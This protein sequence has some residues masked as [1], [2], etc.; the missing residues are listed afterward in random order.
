M[1]RSRLLLPVVALMAPC[2]SGCQSLALDLTKAVPDG[3]LSKDAHAPMDG[4]GG[5]DAG[6]DASTHDAHDAHDG[7]TEDAVATCALGDAACVDATVPFFCSPNASQASFPLQVTG[8]SNPRFTSGVA[9]RNADRAFVFSG[10]AATDAGSPCAIYAQAFDLTADGGALGDAAPIYAPSPPNGEGLYIHDVATA[11]SGVML[12][13]YGFGG[14][15]FKSADLTY[16]GPLYALFLRSGHLGGGAVPGLAVVA[17]VTL[18]SATNLYGQAHVMW[19]DGAGLFHVSWEHPTESYDDASDYSVRVQTLAPDGGVVPGESYAQIPVPSDGAHVSRSAYQGGV[20]VKGGVLGVAYIDLERSA[21]RVALVSGSGLNDTVVGFGDAGTSFVVVAGTPAGF[22]YV[23]YGYDGQTLSTDLVTIQDGG[24]VSAQA[25]AS[26]GGPSDI[27]GG[28]G[29]GDN[30]GGGM[31]VALLH[32]RNVGFAYVSPNAQLLLVADAVLP[33]YS[34]G[35]PLDELG[36]GSFGGS[37][38]FSAYSNAKHQVTAAV[39]GCT[40]P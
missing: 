22:V 10:L 34:D 30:A 20:G 38:L 29:V 13:V 18:D 2:L 37:F 11:P 40:P 32:S 24:E 28:R 5:G 9:T 7:P 25:G 8:A 27:F 19:D 14:G 16:E 3:S 6:R 17:N 35:G 39:S 21:P 1:A 31:G 12:L 33:R 36:V 23:R 15:P 4:K 26:M